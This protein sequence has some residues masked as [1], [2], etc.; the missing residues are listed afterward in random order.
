M[1]PTPL[2]VGGSIFFWKRVYPNYYRYWDSSSKQAGTLSGMLLG[3]RVVKAFAQ[4]PREFDRFRRSSDYLRR[5]R[6]TVEKA[7]RPSRPSW[8]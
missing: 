6:E 2:V 5:S 7:T 3:I 8:R 1:I 4:E